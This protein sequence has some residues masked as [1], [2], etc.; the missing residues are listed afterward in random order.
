MSYGLSDAGLVIPTTQEIIDEIEADELSSISPD[1]DTSE[2]EAIGQIN[3]IFAKKI[4]EAWE[5]LQTLFDALDP[6]NAEASLLDTVSDL[7]GTKREQDTK[8][9][10]TLECI[11]AAGTV[12]PSTATAAVDGEPSNRWVLETPMSAGA[13]GTYALIFRAEQVGVREAVANTITSIVTPIA[14]WSS[15][16][17]P[18]DA[19]PG[20]VKD[21]D[22]QLRTRREDE[23]ATSGSSTAAAIRADLLKV[24]GVK[25]CTVFENKTMSIDADGLPPKSFECVIWDG[26]TP[27][28][29]DAAIRETIYD[30]LVTGIEPV[31]DIGGDVQD[32]ATGVIT[33]VRFSR[34]DQIPI[35]VVIDIQP[36]DGTYPLGGDELIKAQ[37]VA[38][39]QKMKMGQ[40]A[41]RLAIMAAALNTPGLSIEDVPDCTLAAP[42]FPAAPANIPIDPRG[43]ATFDTTDISINLV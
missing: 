26:E 34:A 20:T 41:I 19:T 24:S 30:N 6:D 12:M 18:E 21:T 1:L 17:N 25:E 37:I 32:E 43:I 7:T 23:L 38:F 27:Q 5:L 3:G 10:V 35:T 33:H 42:G 8:G 36:V 22:D 39:G 9:S 31:G 40:D 11:L 28:A 2:D 15:V 16:N 14:G 29:S 13:A 4:A